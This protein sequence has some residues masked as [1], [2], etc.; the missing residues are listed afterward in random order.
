MLSSS[1]QNR[2]QTWITQHSPR[3]FC[4][5][6]PPR[7]TTT[8]A[9]FLF[10]CSCN[11]SLEIPPIIA[12]GLIRMV[13]SS[14]MSWRLLLIGFQLKTQYYLYHHP[15]TSILASH[16]NDFRLKFAWYWSGGLQCSAVF[17]GQLRFLSCGL[18]QWVP[19][20]ML[21]LGAAHRW[22]GGF[23]WSSSFT[24]F[25]YIPCGLNVISDKWIA[26]LTPVDE[27]LNGKKRHN[28]QFH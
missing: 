28:T 11:V 10:C 3:I 7:Q 9:V 4:N 26:V 6:P 12:V 24:T 27:Y 17:S 16:K 5:Y 18:Y 22:E 19:T 13:P 25:L 2:T 20:T 21:R 15:K 14:A 1:G 23:Q 8:L